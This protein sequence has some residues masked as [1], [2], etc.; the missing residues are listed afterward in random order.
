LSTRHWQTRVLVLNNMHDTH[1]HATRP[2][3]QRTVKPQVA[4][5]GVLHSKK[6][7]AGGRVT[8]EFII[9]RTHRFS[10]VVI[11]LEPA[12]KSRNPTNFSTTLITLHEKQV[13]TP[14]QHA[15]D[16]LSGRELLYEFE[17]FCCGVQHT[18]WCFRVLREFVVH[19]RH[20][21]LSVSKAVNNE[22]EAR[23]QGHTLSLAARTVTLPFDRI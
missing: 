4:S 6:P 11:G 22:N 14:Y 18:K 16:A 15:H 21:Q 12:F 19:L 2:F 17:E 13:Q 5:G 8:S 23:C 20:I 10:L 3:F 1:L 9:L 7:P